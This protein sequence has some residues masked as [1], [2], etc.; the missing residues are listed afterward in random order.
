[1]S[2]GSGQVFGVKLPLLPLDGYFLQFV[3]AFPRFWIKNLKSPKF[4][5]KKFNP[6]RKISSNTPGSIPY[7][8]PKIVTNLKIKRVKEKEVQN[9]RKSNKTI[10]LLKFKLR[11]RSSILKNK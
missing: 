7:L 9:L 3:R 4:L 1:M 8:P 6:H 10:Q 11:L 2:H 5:Q